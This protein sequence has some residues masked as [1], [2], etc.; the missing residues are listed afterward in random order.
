MMNNPY[1]AP[2]ASELNRSPFNSHYKMAILLFVI[3]LA[4][5]IFHAATY[6][7][8]AGGRLR[9][10]FDL[11]CVAFSILAIPSLALIDDQKFGWKAKQACIWSGLIL[12]TIFIVEY[13]FGISYSFPLF[14]PYWWTTWPR[15]ALCSLA[16][17]LYLHRE[18]MANP[19]N[20]RG[21]AILI[22][23]GYLQSL[24]IANPILGQ[25]YM[26]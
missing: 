2:P 19:V 17:L 13:R 10:S 26:S 12:L 25:I 8:I 21:L 20:R 11:L 22:S 5:T 3:C 18:T 24:T 4:T 7:V 15:L 9:N 6:S 1:A 16:P 23:C 14:G